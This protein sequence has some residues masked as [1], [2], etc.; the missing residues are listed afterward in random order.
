MTVRA[1][2]H[3]GLTVPDLEQATTF[4]AEAFGAEHVYDMIDE[5][6]SGPAIESGLGVPA[7]A[8]I[9]A[10]RMLRLG[11]GPNLELFTY[12]G[13]P[14][15]DPLVPSDYG[16]QHFCVYVDDMDA[17][18]ARLEKA[19]G[20]LLSAPGELPGGDAGPGNR[21]VYARTPWGSTVELVTYPSAQAYES[22]TA[23]RRWRPAPSA[24]H[25]EQES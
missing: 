14:Q 16:L 10:I 12:S 7:G 17:A 15:R 11:N 21:Y 20:T 3:I 13:V 24:D 25:T 4:F 2:E 1:I 23:L 18:A 22:G 9:E 8:T 5:A 6:L 19:G